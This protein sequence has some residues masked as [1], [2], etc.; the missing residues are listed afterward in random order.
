MSRRRFVAALA[1]LY[2][3][4]DLALG[5]DG[6]RV[7]QPSHI[8]TVPSDTLSDLARAVADSNQ[9]VIYYNPRLMERFGPEISAFVL[10]HEQAHIE[11][12]HR[13]PQ[14]GW[15]GVAL[16]QLLQRWELEADC[17]AAATLAGERP[18]ALVAAIRFFQRMGAERIDREHPTG[19]DRAARLMACGS[20]QARGSPPTSGVPRARPN[21]T[22]IQ[23]R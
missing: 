23:F 11:L 22:T 20:N 18:A 17:Q 10:A 7:I 4:F 19:R 8:R 2:C 12:G 1:I 6:P 14:T 5:Q 13:R 21:P 3:Q 15:S 16:E 9:P